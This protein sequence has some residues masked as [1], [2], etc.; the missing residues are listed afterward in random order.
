MWTGCK[1]D[2]L[3]CMT[4]S[5]RQASTTLLKDHQ[6]R[7]QTVKVDDCQARAIY[8]YLVRNNYVDEQ[9]NVTVT[10]DDVQVGTLVIVPRRWFI[11]EGVHTLVQ[12]TA[13]I[14]CSTMFEDGNVESTGKSSERPI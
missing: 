5:A 9:D 6:A 8:Q 14:V 3:C 12:A 11:E 7:W 10:T 1:A 4:A 2:W 13:T